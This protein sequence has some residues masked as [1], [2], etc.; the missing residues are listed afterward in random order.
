M[1]NVG[2]IFVTATRTPKTLNKTPGNISVIYSKDLE[3]KN[4]DEVADSLHNIPGVK[5]LNYGPKGSLC[6]INLRGLNSTH[7][8]VMINSIP[9]NPPDVGGVDLTNINNEN[10]ERIEIVKGPYSSLYGENA[11]GGAINIITKKLTKEKYSEIQIEGQSSELSRIVF[12]DQGHINETNYLFNV[13]VD[14]ITTQRDNS[15]YNRSSFK[16]NTDHFINKNENISFNIEYINKKKGYPGAKPSEN[17]NLRTT[18][19]LQLGNDDVSNIKDLGKEKRTFISVERK[20]LNVDVKA[21]YNKNEKEIHQ[22]FAF[23]NTTGG[24]T[25]T[26]TIYDH[27]PESKGIDLQYNTFLTDK[28]IFTAGIS[29]IKQ[30]YKYYTANLEFDSNKTNKALFIQDE[31]VANENTTYFLGL[32][33]DDP[34]DY[35]SQISPKINIIYKKNSNTSIKFSAGKAYRTP[36]LSDLHWP[37]SVSVTGNKNLDPE[38]SYSYEIGLDR[39]ITDKFLLNTCVFY[40][41]TNDMIKWAPN[42]PIGG[43]GTPKWQPS[44]IGKVK[45][46]GLEINADIILNKYFRSSFSYTRLN[47]KQKND[48]LINSISYEMKEKERNS[49][50]TPKNKLSADLYYD[51]LKGI[52]LNLNCEYVSETYNYYTNWAAGNIA[53]GDLPTTEKKISSYSVFNITVNKKINDSAKLFIEVNNIFNK[54]YSIQFGPSLNDENYPMDG[55][56][57][58][59]GYKYRF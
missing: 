34:D 11:V 29:I 19:E 38:R 39:Q 23:N 3:T 17:K 28:D 4:I 36:T 14:N 20:F 13:N 7:T 53:T 57:I 12:T 16:L 30:N 46:L 42:G 18:S 37:N 8:L 21:F 56:D 40:Q 10:I 5:V 35:S 24:I 32:R 41:H 25:E 45:T 33:Y 58:R 49:S 15:H 51:T 48:E 9:I 2:D 6:S 1:F 59:A 31:I 50:H 43:L 54:K 22:W 26:E 55:T 44:N 52:D 47:S 27:T